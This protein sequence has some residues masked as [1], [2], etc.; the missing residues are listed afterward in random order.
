MSISG[1]ISYIYCTCI[2]WVAGTNIFN[3]ASKMECKRRACSFISSRLTSQATAA[4]V[5][6]DNCEQAT[7]VTVARDSSKR[8]IR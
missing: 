5:A 4:G 7:V 6:G 8:G 1:E 3:F 2:L